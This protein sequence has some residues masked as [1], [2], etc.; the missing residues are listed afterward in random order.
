MRW[1]ITGASG[2]LGANAVRL[3]SPSHDVVGLVRDIN[4]APWCAQKVSADLIA[5][6]ALERAVHEI[7]PDVVL[8]CAG[9]ADLGA[10]EANEGLA[11][12]VN[13]EASGVLASAANRAGA[14]FI[15]VSTDAVFDGE[16]GW[17]AEDDP[18]SP[19]NAYGRSK[20]AGEE[21]VLAAHPTAVIA[22]TNFFGWSPNGHRSILEFFI[23]ELGAGNR[24]AGFVDYTVTSLFVEDVVR[25]LELLTASDESG[26]FHLVARDALS[27]FDFGTLVAAEFG[28]D[29]SLIEASE[30]LGHPKNLSLRSDRLAELRGSALPTQAEGIARARVTARF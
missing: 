10:C 8:H 15:Y 25:S 18:V 19:N 14:S 24:V 29:A 6:D 17:Y 28:L 11:M 7:A 26:V 12:R 13:A 9:I 22:R 20:V 4:S 5:A 27:K 21:A 1:L 16:R 30:G 23:R 3:L 2:F